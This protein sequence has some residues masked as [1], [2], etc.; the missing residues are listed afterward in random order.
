[1]EVPDEGSLMHG[2]YWPARRMAQ[3]AES[4]GTFRFRGYTEDTTAML[5]RSENYMMRVSLTNSEPTI[6]RE[7]PDRTFHDLMAIYGHQLVVLEWDRT[8][9][10]LSLKRLRY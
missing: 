8:T 10:T 5:L 1:V 2:G 6:L 9:G 3:Y 4:V 7:R